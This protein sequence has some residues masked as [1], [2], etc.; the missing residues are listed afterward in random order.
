MDTS[1]QPSDERIVVQ[2]N[3]PWIGPLGRILCGFLLAVLVISVLANLGQWARYQTYFQGNDLLEERFHSGEK[4]AQQKIAVIE[5]KGSILHG[6]GFVKRQIDQV[7]EDKNVKAV[8]LRINSPGGTVTAS[9]YLFHHL[10]QLRQDRKL[11]LVVSM[12]SLCASGGYYLAMAVG[13]QPEAIFAEPTTW[14]GSI[15]VVI[16]HFDASELLKNW[17]IKDD[18][19]ASHKLK[20]MGSPTRLLSDEDRAEERKILQGLVD[21][22]FAGFKDVVRYG[23]PHLR[24]D[25]KQLD[26]AATG[27]IFTADQA[28]QLGL[29]DK[30][31]FIEDAIERVTALAKLST[32]QVRVVQYKRRASS[33]M[34]IVMGPNAHY[35]NR[36]AISLERVVDLTAPRA[37]YLS[38]WL[39]AVLTNSK[40]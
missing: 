2:T 27:Q 14:T 17:H 5:V 11:P 28:R 6:D 33:L 7:R 1:G 30:I 36:T 18:S 25:D 22:S 37:Y 32:E 39:P 9:D 21:E 10:K 31:G 16:P 26:K 8:V 29:V 15:G 12:G 19:I 24:D 4:L 23:R 3:T 20:Q 13:D 34:E 35:G 40:R 38:T